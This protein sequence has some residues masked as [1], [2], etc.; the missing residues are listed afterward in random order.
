M[1]VEPVTMGT[2]SSYSALF[3]VFVYCHNDEL[4]IWG[5]KQ[6]IQYIYDI[7]NI[8]GRVKVTLCL[9]QVTDH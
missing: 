5:K 9:Q 2:E 6:H 4:N 7:Q 1:Y 8:T 3:K